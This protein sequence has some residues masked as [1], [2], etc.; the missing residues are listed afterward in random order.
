[1]NKSNHKSVRLKMEALEDRSVPAVSAD[2]NGDGFQDLVV[3]VPAADDYDAENA[4][5]VHVIYGSTGGLTAYG[6]SHLTQSDLGVDTS[7]PWDFFGYAL[8]G[9]DFDADGLDDLA[10]AAMGEDAHSGA[11][12]ILYGS[13]DGLGAGR[14]QRWDQ[15]SSGIADVGEQG[16]RFGSALA[17]GDFDGNGVD[18]LAVGVTDEVLNGVRAGVVHVLYGRAGIGLSAEGSQLWSQESTGIA[19]RAEQLDRF[20]ESLAVGDFNGDGKDDLAVG[21]SWE[22][23]G[24][25][26]GAGAV[27][28]LYGSVAGLTATGSQLWSQNSYGIADSAESF[29]RFGNSLA[30]GDF[31]RDGKDDLAIGVRWEY[32]GNLNS[33]GA[34]HVLYGT[35]NGLSATNNQYWTKDSAGIRGQCQSGDQFG[36]SLVAG[37]FD[38]NGY[39]DLAIGA[40]WTV[41]NGLQGAGAVHVLFG[42]GSGITAAGNQLWTRSN[43]EPGGS[44]YEQF[45]KSLAAADYNGD[46]KADLAIRTPGQAVMGVPDVGAVRVLYGRAADL[47]DGQLTRST[48]T[49]GLSA[50]GTQLWTQAAL[51]M[52]GSPYDFFGESL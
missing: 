44:S 6:S 28:V 37:D 36:Y 32:V 33:A 42:S 15:D 13:P 5:V 18:D 50:T 40:P 43:F 11:V 29:D 27:H 14:M 26:R 8:A 21:T 39:D 3:G 2:F 49:A 22:S 25:V 46:G 52:F 23:V 47:L 38:G 45:G 17:T 10:I 24:T 30:A 48:A 4:G 9:G 12:Y 34:V 20:G 1:M 19:E 7:E 41:V 31:N 16:D 35:A 51:G